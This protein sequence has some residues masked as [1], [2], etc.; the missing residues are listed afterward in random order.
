MRSRWS[1]PF[2]VSQNSRFFRLC[3]ACHPALGV[4]HLVV[5]RLDFVMTA[6]GTQEFLLVDRTGDCFFQLS[7]GLHS[8]FVL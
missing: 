6:E 2:V 8:A 5:D 1:V 3:A 4:F 7:T